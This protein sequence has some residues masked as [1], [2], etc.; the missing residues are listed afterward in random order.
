MKRAH[1]IGRSRQILSV[2]GVC[3]LLVGW[4]LC[5]CSRVVLLWAGGDELP[6]VLMFGYLFSTMETPLIRGGS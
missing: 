3:T 4:V 2:Y 6:S 5:V 1:G